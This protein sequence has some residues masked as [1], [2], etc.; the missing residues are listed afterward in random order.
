MTTENEVA[1]VLAE[2]DA[3]WER[4]DFVGLLTLWDSDEPDPLYVAEEAPVMRGWDAIRAYFQGTQSMIAR[5]GHRR[6]DTMIREIGPGLARVFYQMHWNAEL[7]PG[8]LFGG[9][10]MA[11]DVR[12]TV[13]LRKKPEGWRIFHYMEA[14]P[15]A[16]LQM[17]EAMDA[18]VDPDFRRG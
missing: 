11:G 10:L 17:R 8:G 5:I 3:Y 9:T 6:E 7:A 16:M 2:L 13:L 14:P 1:A 12:V 4:H 15:A 18:K